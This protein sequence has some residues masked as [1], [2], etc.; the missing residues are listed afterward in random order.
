MGWW[1][2]SLGSSR[3]GIMGLMGVVNVQKMGSGVG[4]G[5]VSEKGVRVLGRESLI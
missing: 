2:R 4:E 3:K 1:V 5:K